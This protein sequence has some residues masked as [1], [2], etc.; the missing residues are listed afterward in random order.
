MATK[1]IVIDAKGL[2]T[3]PNQLSAPNGYM[4]RADNVRINKPGIIQESTSYTAYQFVDTNP[5]TGFLQPYQTSPGRAIYAQSVLLGAAG[6]VSGT[7]ERLNYRLPQTGVNG[8]IAI[9]KPDG[10]VISS[11]QHQMS[12]Q[13]FVAN[14]NDYGLYGPTGNNTGLV[15]GNTGEPGGVLRLDSSSATARWDGAGIAEALT[16]FYYISTS[17]PSGANDN[18]HGITGLPAP[19]TTTVITASTNNNGTAGGQVAYRVVYAS[20]DPQNNLVRGAPSGRMIVYSASSALTYGIVIPL[21]KSG[22]YVGDILQLY[23]SETAYAGTGFTAEPSDELRQCYEYIVQSADITAGYVAIGND[24]SSTS[25]PSGPAL[26]TNASQEGILAAKMRP[27]AAASACF[28]KGTSFY[29]AVSD[30]LQALVISILGLSGWSTTGGSETSFA[31]GGITAKAATAEDLPNHKFHLDTTSSTVSMQLFNTARSIARVLSWANETNYAVFASGAN[32]YTPS[33]IVKTFLTCDSANN[34][35]TTAN[36]PAGTISPAP[37]SNSLNL[38]SLSKPEQV[39]FSNIGEPEAVP[40]INYLVVGTPGIPVYAVSALKDSVFVFKPEGLYRITGSGIEDFRVELF[41]QTIQLPSGSQRSVSSSGSTIFAMTLNGVIALNESGSRLISL[42]IDD[43]ISP[44][45]FTTYQAA[46]CPV[47]GF[48]SEEDKAYYLVLTPTYTLGPVEPGTQRVYRYNFYTSSW[49]K[50][51]LFSS[52]T[53]TGFFR[54]RYST[55]NPA[56]QVPSGAIL[57]SEGFSQTSATVLQAQ[58]SSGWSRALAPTWSYCTTQN[59]EDP[60]MLTRFFDVSLSLAGSVFSGSMTATFSSDS[61]AAPTV[62]TQTPVSTNLGIGFI[63]FQVPREHSYC[64]R[65]EVTI[66]APDNGTALQCNACV[67]SYDN[68]SDRVARQ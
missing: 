41:D 5:G 13:G 16:P 11:Y 3:D 4:S 15:S 22:V 53:L 56:F 65:F 62:V 50:E 55:Y 32:D 36:L 40:D 37:S 25:P 48:A 68:V 17:A 1:R 49:N 60:S 38:T 31:I 46:V 42:S 47:I 58:D 18:N 64:G 34:V 39:Y 59:L 54:L 10:T 27:P 9:T 28:Y 33:I 63:R 2:Y 23:R 35:L 44:W 20:K 52:S 29:A 14:G 66:K 61:G 21:K 24:L 19:A 26:Y 8:F 45:K 67:F 43:L 57:F 6:D 7:Y 12:T 51:D 30:K